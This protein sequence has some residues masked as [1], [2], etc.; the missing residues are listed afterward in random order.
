V[1]GTA[2]EASDEDFVVVLTR[3]DAG[4]DL[5]FRSG[6]NIITLDQIRSQPPS[7]FSAG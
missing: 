1:Y 4:Q 7:A 3:P 5:I 2:G 6:V